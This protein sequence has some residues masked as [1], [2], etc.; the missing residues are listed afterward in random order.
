MEIVAHMRRNGNKNHC[1]VNHIE[2]RNI[3]IEIGGYIQS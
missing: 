2:L 1:C 3:R